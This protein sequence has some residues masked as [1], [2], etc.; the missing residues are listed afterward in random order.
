M[1]VKQLG[2]KTGQD[3]NDPNGSASAGLGNRYDFIRVIFACPGLAPYR[4]ATTGWMAE[5]DGFS[6]TR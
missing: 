1:S 3:G 2:G 6:V 5:F 4:V